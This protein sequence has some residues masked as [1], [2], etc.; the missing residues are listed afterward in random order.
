MAF[1]YN[2]DCYSNGVQ[3]CTREKFEEIIHS[4]DVR[5]KCTAYRNAVLM[6]RNGKITEKKF[7]E[8]KE[9]HKET[10]QVFFWQ[11]ASFQGGVRSSRLATPSNLFMFDADH[12][13]DARQYFIDKVQAHLAEC[14]IVAAHITPSYEGL[15]LVCR[16]PENLTLAESQQWLA[17]KLG[18][19]EFDACCKDYARCSFAVPHDYF[20]YRD[21]DVLFAKHVEPQEI[22][23]AEIDAIIAKNIASRTVTRQISQPKTTTT[24]TATQEEIADAY[25]EDAA[26]LMY[27]GVPYSRIITE[28]FNLT[29]GE[30]SEAQHNRNSRLFDLAMQLRLISDMDQGLMFRVMPNYGLDAKE[31]RTI[32]GSACRYDIYPLSADMKTA[33]SLASSSSP[34]GNDSAAEKAAE[35]ALFATMP[36]MPEKNP[37]LVELILGPVSDKFKPAVAN[38]MF[39]ALGAYVTQVKFPYIFDGEYHEA[40]FMSCLMG[41]TASGKSC[42]D[43]PVEFIMKDIYTDS[44]LGEKLLRDWREDVTTKGSIAP[45]KKKPKPVLQH[46]PANFTPASFLERMIN[47][48][49]RFLFTQIDELTRLYQLQEGKKNN[50]YEIIKNAF[51]CALF[52][53]ARV[54]A[55]SI[56]GQVQLRWNLVAATTIKNGKKFFAQGLT[57]GVVNRFNF[58]RIPKSRPH[59]HPRYGEYT[60]EQFAQLQPYLDNLRAV[61]HTTIRCEEALALARRMVSMCEDIY[62]KTDDET[63]WELAKRACVIAYR[64]ACVLYVANGCQ[65]EPEIE[66][67]CIWSLE[68]D[69]W[70]KMDFFGAAIDRENAEEYEPKSRGPR[71]FLYRLPQVFSLQELYDACPD[72][73]QEKLHN[74]L[75][76]WRFRHKIKNLPDGRFMRIR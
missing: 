24:A 9:K 27:N 2:N 22:T 16:C 20:L 33:I 53:A 61:H 5:N 29:G 8:L 19:E 36:K 38:A 45:K 11:T 46:L 7:K 48:G 49:G 66:D 17:M 69:M 43:S 41:P 56:S 26:S 73:S 51:D 65:W 3:T 39:P 31:M 15:R 44:R 58:S 75:N 37:S 54:G 10:L 57:D 60:P 14:G 34:L 12:I 1:A 47:A 4:Q 18:I 76:Q 6:Y 21:D 64:K 72:T 59:D 62:E 74:T 68:Y 28:W 71:G 63:Y 40:A 52:G 35:D 32:I 70:C 13:G 55:E 50:H 67:F 25:P 42:L 30:P 23:Q